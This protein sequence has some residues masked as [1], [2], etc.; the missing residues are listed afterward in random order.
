MGGLSD[1]QSLVVEVAGMEKLCKVSDVPKAAMKGFAVKGRQILVANIDGNFYVVDAV[2]PHMNGY[3]PDGRLEQNEVV[4]P[5]H[6]ARYDLRTGKL[7]KNVPKII[8]LATG[9]GAE[10]L[11][12]FKVEL[13]ADD[14]FVDI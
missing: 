8:R 13:E 9:R 11:Q 1:G 6:G 7:M 14:I 4:C 3:L 2:C 10:D 5:K 12:T